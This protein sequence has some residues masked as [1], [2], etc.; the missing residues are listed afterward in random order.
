MI[1]MFNHWSLQPRTTVLSCASSGSTATNGNGRRPRL[2]FDLWSLNTDLWTLNFGK[3]QGRIKQSD[4]EVANNLGQAWTNFAKYGWLSTWL[5]K[6]L[7]LFF[8]K[9]HFTRPIESIALHLVSS[10]VWNTFQNRNH[11]YIH[12]SRYKSITVTPGGRRCA[13]NSISLP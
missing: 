4:L 2:T 9:F 7:H 11:S 8:F 1:S 13:I 3:L 6:L 12:R 5:K 10:L